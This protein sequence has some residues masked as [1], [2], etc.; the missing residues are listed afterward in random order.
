MKKENIVDL[1]AYKDQRDDNEET[2]SISEEL[3]TA[4]QNLI[5]RMREFGP[6]SQS[7]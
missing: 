6:L 5:H 4:I 7:N 2:V 1:L 3:Q